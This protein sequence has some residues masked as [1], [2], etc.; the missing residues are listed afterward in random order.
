[1]RT[2]VVSS[3]IVAVLGSSALAGCGG[4]AETK[5]AVVRDSAGITIVANSGGIWEQGQEWIVTPSPS[6]NIGVLEGAPEYQLF[7]VRN[8]LRMNNGNIVVAASNELRFY[9]SEGRYLSTSGREGGGPGE[10]QQLG[11]VRPYPGDSIVAY[12]FGQVRVS[13]LD[14]DGN[15]GRSHR[16]IPE[17][18][19]GFVMGE[20]V[21]ADGT[22]LVKA[23]Q[24][25]RG[26][27]AEGNSRDE[28]HYHTYSTTGEFIDSVAS[29]PGPDQF[30]QTGGDAEHRFVAVRQPP[31]GRVPVMATFG[32]HF[33]YGSADVYEIECYAQ[34]GTLE[35][36]VRREYGQRPV[37]ENDVTAFVERQLDGIEDET[38]LRQT[39]DA[40]DEM[41][42]PEVMPAYEE[43]R[44]DELGNLWVQ[45]YEPNR[46]VETVWTVFQPDGQM[47]GSVTLAANFEVNQIGDDFV[48]G[49]W[50]DEFD[51]EHV[52]VYGL[53]KPGR[54][55]SGEQ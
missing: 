28:E 48:L 25:F 23:P 52:H 31:F 14:E 41:D 17:G 15:F 55:G 51:V 47:L 5:L 22:L 53:I 3:T 26:G 9:D 38:I 13:L 35:M 12:D 54:E 24:L 2:L 30:I 32:R 42:I 11:W 36:L 7:R 49:V 16:I 4:E 6:L 44:I 40:Y 8:A 37:T 19:F 29:L 20:S 1:M 18:E 46:E 50:R 45:D 27:L 21:F 43:L 39:R 10:F 34:D 33:F